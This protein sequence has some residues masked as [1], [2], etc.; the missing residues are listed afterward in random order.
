MSRRRSERLQCSPSANGRAPLRNAARACQQQ[1][2]P[3]R[4]SPC[5]PPATSA[6]GAPWRGW[7]AALQGGTPAALP[8]RRDWP[9]GTPGTAGRASPGTGCRGTPR[10]DPD[11]AFS[12]G[13]SLRGR[14]VRAVA[15]PWPQSGARR[16][17]PF[18]RRCGQREKKSLGVCG[19]RG[20]AIR[21]QAGARGSVCSTQV[22]CHLDIA[23]ANDEIFNDLHRAWILSLSDHRLLICPSLQGMS[24]GKS[25]E[26]DQHF[27]NC[28]NM[29]AGRWLANVFKHATGTFIN[30]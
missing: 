22:S 14:R 16:W 10:T 6:C 30:F 12:S 8:G 21:I 26:K 17:G 3:S 13:L 1:L 28:A 23:G 15:P 20:A 11:S 18:V 2:R 25:P 19:K 7:A 4:D 29:C 9:S 24:S 5:A 27:L